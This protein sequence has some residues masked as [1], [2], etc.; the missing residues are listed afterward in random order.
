MADF[1]KW[2]YNYGHNL[3]PH[4]AIIV[5]GMAYQPPLIGYKQLLN[6]AAYSVPD[7][8]GWIFVGCGALMLI[9]ILLEWSKKAKQKKGKLAVSVLLPTVLL[10]N[11]CN[12]EPEP[13]KNGTDAC[14]FCKMTISDPRFGAEIVT[15]TGKIYKFDDIACLQNFI[16]TMDEAA[17]KKNSIYFSDF[18]GNHSLIAAQNCMLLE[19]EELK[20]PMNGHLAAFGNKDSLA[21]AMEIYPG[22][23][24]EFAPLK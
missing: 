2:E 4:A 15:G 11:S 6:F 1:W 16:P 21:S 18:C 5:P 20:C 7:T 13:I 17:R 12:K 14:S 23:K 22:K 8:G 19:S 3:D 9:G 24:T 10:L